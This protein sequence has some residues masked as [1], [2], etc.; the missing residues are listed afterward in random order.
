MSLPDDAPARA[1]AHSLEVSRA[2][3][4]DAEV[5]ARLVRE[6]FRSEAERYGIEIPPVRE[7]TADIISA[8][9]QGDVVLIARVNGEPVGTVRGHTQENG[10]VMVRRLAVLPH[11][12]RMGVACALMAVLEQ[13]YPDTQ[14]FELFTGTDTAPAIALYESLGY[15]RTR[16]EDVQPGVR[17]VY[18]EKRR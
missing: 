3:A 12:R 13:A 11:A 5:I 10:I 2:T 15:T 14:C 4:A 6:G 16:E 9:E 1:D 7:V 8:F 17:L 18:L